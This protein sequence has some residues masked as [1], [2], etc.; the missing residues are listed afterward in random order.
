[1][2]SALVA[3]VLLTHESPAAVESMHAYWSKLDPGH[4]VV[5]AYGGALPNFQQ[6]EMDYAVYVDDRW[7]RTKDHP[8]E[9]QSYLGVFRAV[10]PIVRQLGVGYVH[11]AEYDEIP[12]IAGMNAKLLEILDHENADVL[13]HRL[14]RL[15]QT[16]HPH[17]TFH[18]SDAAFQAYW[19][20]LSC[21]DDSEVVLS[22]LGCGSFWRREAFE[23]VAMLEL[24]SRIYL[25][26]M[27][28]TAAHHLGYRV[29]S[30]RE[31]DQFMG[32]ETLK[33]PQDFDLYRQQGAWRVHPVKGY[34]STP[35]A[36]V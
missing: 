19:E 7:L 32:P 34:W 18:R 35:T 6:L 22:M 28:P 30:I 21:R 31:Q 23:D 20:K 36:S 33:K 29:R 13:G 25:E 16:G 15:D 11:V 4:P 5:I 2:D 24:P 14:Q 8:R 26:L 10:L 1:M 17:Y 27:L 12:L 9:Q 3:T